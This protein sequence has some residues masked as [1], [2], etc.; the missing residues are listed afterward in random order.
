MS[1]YKT[2]IHFRPSTK[3]GNVKCLNGSAHVKETFDI[4]DV[5]C[6][7]CLDKTDEDQERWWDQF[8]ARKSK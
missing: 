1:N 6:P 2:D 3:T 4:R 7:K 5:T 8:F